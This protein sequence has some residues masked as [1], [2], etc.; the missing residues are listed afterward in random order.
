[1]TRY[2]LLLVGK[3][4]VVSALS[5]L[6]DRPSL[7]PTSTD[8]SSVVFNSS[9]PAGVF[10][11][12]LGSVPVDAFFYMVADQSIVLLKSKT[13]EVV[14]PESDRPAVNLYFIGANGAPKVTGITFRDSMSGFQQVRYNDLY[15]GIDLL[16][17]GHKDELTAT[18]T[19]SAG[20]DARVV[21]F[22]LDRDWGTDLNP[23][24]YQMIE[25]VR[26]PVEARF[27]D[28]L[29]GSTKLEL[30]KMEPNSPVHVGFG[31]SL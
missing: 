9:D 14:R 13:I 17:A 20:A 5:L 23:S 28:G 4:L 12:N 7:N 26:Q 3:A 30:G 29:F 31:I 19:L 22:K 25:G 8:A 16:L 1:M 18:M 6:G 21:H 15:E 2:V 24:A 10:F 11:P 27:V